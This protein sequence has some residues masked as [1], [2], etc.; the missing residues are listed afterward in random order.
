MQEPDEDFISLQL[1][2]SYTNTAHHRL[3]WEIV[4]GVYKTPPSLKVK[5]PQ[6]LSTAVFTAN[7]RKA[8][9]SI[10]AFQV[11]FYYFEVTSGSIRFQPGYTPQSAWGEDRPFCTDLQDHPILR[12]EFKT[13]SI[14]TNLASATVSS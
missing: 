4:W 5:D 7:P 1:G 8:V 9:V 11:L 10:S 12:T 13:H 2:S 6:L 3:S 14:T